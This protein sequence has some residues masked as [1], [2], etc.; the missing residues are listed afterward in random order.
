VAAGIQNLLFSIYLCHVEWIHLLVAKR[1]SMAYKTYL[2]T[3]PPLLKSVPTG[4]FQVAHPE[5]IGDLLIFV[6]RNEISRTI[7][8]FTGRYGYS[9]LAID[10]GEVDVPTGKRVMIEVTMGV[11]VHYSFQ[12][13]YGSR[14][15]VRIPL[16]LTGIDVEQ[17]CACVQKKVGEKFD[18]LEAITLGILDNP[19]RQICSDLATNCLPEAIRDEI[20]RCHRRAVIHP[21]AAVRD[22][23]PG[24]RIRLFM[25]PNGFAEFFGAPP[26]RQIREPNQLI[27]PQIQKSSANNFPPKFWKWAD[28]IVT[29]AWRQI[30]KP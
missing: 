20:V 8:N 24:L 16:R 4:P 2:D 13:A 1:V 27:D 12:A 10:C 9:H 29:S 22:Q 21:L 5:A 7:N 19:A 14:P 30:Q 11:G 6:P 18:N 26:G 23:R 28:T 15:Y 17:F 3:E 25:S